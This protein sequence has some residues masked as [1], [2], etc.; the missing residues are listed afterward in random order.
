MKKLII[1]CGLL[2]STTSTFADEKLV[3]SNVERVTV[4]TQGAQVFRTTNISVGAGITHLV[5]TGL[6]QGINPASIQA[7]GKGTF[8]VT[9][10][11]HRIKYPEPAK[12]PVI[13]KTITK[14]IEQ[15]EDSLTELDFRKSEIAERLKSLSLEK[16]M[17]VKNKLAKGE[18]KSDSLEV[19]IKA[20]EF[21]H[22]RLGELN[23]LIGKANREQ[24]QINVST[25]EVTQKLNEL[26]AF[27][28]D[29]EPEKPYQP[30]NQ[31]VVTISAEAPAT[32]VVELSYMVGGCKAHL[33]G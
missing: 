9:D 4:F 21:F 12:T 31:V 28:D 5:F 15:L 14:Q 24:F 33:Q 6:T 2:L 32:G 18:G 17:I 8:V 16:D 3:K 13:P 7:G 19:L 1:A 10:V 30:E 22:K 11:K 27:K 23:S 29:T 26:R 20:M 25:N